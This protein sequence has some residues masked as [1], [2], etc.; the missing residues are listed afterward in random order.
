[1]KFNQIR[2]VIAVAER[3]SLRSAARYLDV[4][5]P[6][7]TKSIRELERELGVTLFERQ[8]KGV[9]LTAMG[10]LFLRRAKVIQSEV[11]RASD[12]ISQFKGEV[13]GKVTIGLSTASHI[14]LLPNTLNDFRQRYSKAKL[15]IIEGLFSSSEAALKNGTLD[16]Y[17]GPLSEESL[18][19]ELLAEK[20]FDNERAVF[21][22]KDHPLAAATTLAELSSAEWIATSITVQTAAELGPLFAR[23]N[24]PEPTIALQSH[25][26]LTMIAAAAYSDLLT[27]LPIQWTEFPWSNNLLQRIH[28]KE[29]LP[30]PSIFI[31]RRANLPLTPAAEYFCDMIR[32]ASVTIQKKWCTSESI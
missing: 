23:Y 7:I 19:G 2:N 15:E 26:A 18:T 25:S 31:V 24:L 28:I 11:Q 16:C 8:S 3:G 20:L 14:A 22:R 12:E 10:E 4:A 30:A 13:H 29:R 32:R 6:A 27:M 9:V 5:Q 17:I 21:C 1:M